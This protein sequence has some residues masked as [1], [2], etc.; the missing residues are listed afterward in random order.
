MAFPQLVQRQVA[1]HGHAQ[2]NLHARLFDGVNL[3]EQ[4]AVGQ[5]VFRDAPVE[6][7]AGHLL[8]LVDVHLM[9]QL[10]QVVGAGEAG[11]TRADD[12]HAL[13]RGLERD[14][15]GH[16]ERAAEGDIAHEAL[17]GADGQ[18]FV[19][20]GA[21]AVPLAGMRADAAAHRGEGVL[22]PD[23]AVG[24]HQPPRGHEVHVAGHVHR[25]GAGVA[26]GRDVEVGAHARVAVAVVDVGFVLVAEVPEGGEDGVGRGLP[27]AAHG[28]ILQ[29]F[30]QLLEH[31]QVLGHALA[32]GDA[33]Q[34]LQHALGAHAAGQA[35]A[36]AFVADEVHEVAGGIDHAGVLVHDD[37]AAG[38]HDRAEPG[39]ALV[40]DGGVEV[41]AGEAPAAGPAGLDG[42]EALAAGDAA[43]DGIEDLAQWDAHGHLDQAG[44]VDLAG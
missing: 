8:G 16:L 9:A 3:L 40:I 43:A 1:A 2:V 38:T 10:G 7:A 41:R 29:R 13:A 22:L 32:L 11:G 35:L 18:R 28:G 36:A 37:E 34:D 12:G 42:L 6:H 33:L 17:D 21:A 4:H 44:V 26:A 15:V 39:Q 20:L 31:I 19:H 14:F 5:A 30:G 23:E 27:Q 24:V 25:G